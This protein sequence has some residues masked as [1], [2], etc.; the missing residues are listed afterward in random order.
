LCVNVTDVIIKGNMNKN[1]NII[2]I[3]VTF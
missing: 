2:S 1:C 3:F